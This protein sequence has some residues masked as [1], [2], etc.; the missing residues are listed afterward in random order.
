MALSLCPSTSTGSNA[1]DDQHE[2]QGNRQDEQHPEQT[3]EQDGKPGGETQVIE[4]TR[5][6]FNEWQRLMHTRD[7]HVIWMPWGLKLQAETMI[8]QGWTSGSVADASRNVDKIQSCVGQMLSAVNGIVVLCADDMIIAGEG[9]NT[10]G[11]RFRSAVGTILSASKN[12]QMLD[13]QKS[14]SAS[15]S[16]Q[17]SSASPRLLS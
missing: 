1:P 13:E 9:V 4:L 12:N 6:D 10:I 14:P 7:G 8:L 16:E 5:D 15:R 3:Q 11:L 17:P 2:Q